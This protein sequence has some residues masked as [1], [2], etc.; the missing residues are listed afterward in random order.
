M[1]M[2]DSF[3]STM[4]AR[5]RNEWLVLMSVQAGVVDRD[6]ARRAGFSDR[7]IS[8][9][10][11]SGRWQ[12]IYPGVYATFSG[13]LSRSASLWAAIRWAGQGAMLS[14]E[15]AAEVH[16]LIDSPLGE[17]IH[18]TV[19][20]RRRPAQ[21]RRATGITVH[22]SDQSQT[23]FAG[24]FK[25]PRTRIEDTV[26]DLVSTAPDF[27]HGYTWISRAI[28]R[29]LVTVGVL[30]AALDERSRIRWRQWLNDAFT[31]ARDGVLS[32][33]EL[34]YVRNVERAHGLPASQ[35]Q[36]RRELNGRVHYKDNWYPEYRL[37]VEVD[38]P[39][40]H[41]NEQVQRDK[42][43]DNANLATDDVRTFRFGP[44]AVTEQACKTAT[45]VAVTLQRNGWPG[46]PRPCR[47]PACV[48]GQSSPGIRNDGG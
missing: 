23:Q 41:Q 39:A 46:S 16:G 9:R 30:R 32:P 34:H 22:R 5:A 29:R 44:V 20:L 18:V 1:Y 11:D 14:H 25:L 2:S 31:E 37:A 10:L 42:D 4:G 38:G 28:S 19:P 12:R 26:L 15:T 35:H 40:Y 27:D 36:A 8:H 17:S 33:L 13:R 43:R 3:E 24:P 6:Q 47:R 7:Q 21:L 48:I 45:M